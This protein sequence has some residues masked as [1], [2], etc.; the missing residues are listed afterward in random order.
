MQ[1]RTI[2][3]INTTIYVI[4]NA[5]HCLVEFAICGGVTYISVIIPSLFTYIYVYFAEISKLSKTNKELIINN[6]T[7]RVI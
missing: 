2:I 7:D 3:K 6:I 4:P 5:F 1:S